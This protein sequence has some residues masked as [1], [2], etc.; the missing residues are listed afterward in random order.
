MSAKRAFLIAPVASLLIAEP[1]TQSQPISEANV[2]ELAQL[3]VDAYRNSVED[4]GL[5]VQD[6]RARLGGLAAGGAG[7]LLPG[8]WRAIYAGS[9]TPV[10][11]ILCTEWR[12]TPFIA[13]LMTLPAHRNRGFAS[14]L[15]REVALSVAR[16][17]RS[18][19]GVMVHR[20]DGAL[21]LCAEL[22]FREL[23]VPSGVS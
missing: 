18:A 1:S 23:V 22:G 13:E 4:I 9:P 7:E 14:S 3:Y 17:G 12:G 21:A 19:I 6:A 15:I 10:S 2:P 20:D 11:A 5:S 16:R 8:G